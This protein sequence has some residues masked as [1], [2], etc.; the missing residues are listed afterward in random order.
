MMQSEM[1]PEGISRILVRPTWVEVNLDAIDFNVKSIKKFFHK[2]KLIGVL[3][4]D[5]CGFGVV[6]CGLAMEAAGADMLAVGNPFD[7]KVL[8]D[9]GVKCPILLFGSYLPESASEIVSLGATPTIFDRTCAEAFAR[10]AREVLNGPLDVFVK[11]D[12][13]LGRLGAPFEEGAFL[14]KIVAENPYLRLVGLYSHGSTRIPDAAYDEQAQKVEK[15]LSE[16][17]AQ[18][19]EI[20]IRLITSTSGILRKHYNYKWA[21][22]IQPGRLLFGIKD[23]PTAPEPEMEIRPA[24]QGFRSRIIQIKKVS[25]GDPAQYG[26]YRSGNFRYGVLPLGW[27]D[28]FLPSEYIKSGAL[29]RGVKIRFHRFTAE[30]SMIDLTD[31]P[32]AK[33]GDVVTIIGRDGDS[34]IDMAQFSQQVGL[35]VS[36]ITRRFH[37]HLS[38]IYFRKGKPIKVKILTGDHIIQE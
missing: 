24:L 22:A 19:I 16:L 21:N 33:V 23:P 12:S 27:T 15:V 26:H 7:V 11:V 6:E 25:Q 31:V 1:L 34:F 29:V 9:S 13:G 32:D 17:Q 10:A 14:A 30:H 38:F 4:G 8:R 18:G 37:R 35:V 5:A 36:D 28:M 20:P 2:M 3:K